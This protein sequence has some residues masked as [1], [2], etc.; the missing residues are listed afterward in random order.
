M[1]AYTKC[2]KCGSEDLDSKCTH[3][4]DTCMTEKLFCCNCG[5]YWYERYTLIL[6]DIEEPEKDEASDRSM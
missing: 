5:Y 3:R 2:P 1:K 4:T 6:E